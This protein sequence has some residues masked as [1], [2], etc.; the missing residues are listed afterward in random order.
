MNLPYTQENVEQLYHLIGK[1]VWHLQHLE[2]VVASF[3]ALKV[4]QKQRGKGKR[5]QKV[6]VERVLEKQK[7]LT[8]GPLIGTA[9]AQKTIPPH[10][11]KR[12]EQILNDRNWLIHRC[13]TGEFLSLRNVKDREQLFQKLSALS[14]EAIT[15]QDEIHNLFEGWFKEVGYDLE[16]SYRLAEDMLKNAESH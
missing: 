16:L 5:H 8:L 1:A 14:Q 3:T 7:G 13:V 12:F 4:L 9:K 10:L 15:L 2:N 6:E 11:I